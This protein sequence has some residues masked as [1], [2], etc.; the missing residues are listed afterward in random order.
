MLLATL[1]LT[2]FTL[3]Q[4]KAVQEFARAAVNKPVRDQGLAVMTSSTSVSEF[5]QK[6]QALSQSLGAEPAA[7]SALLADAP[8]PLASVASG[9]SERGSGSKSAAEGGA[10][11]TPSESA[12]AAIAESAQASAATQEDAI[13]SRPLGSGSLAA[14]ETSNVGG[15]AADAAGAASGVIA[16]ASGAGFS[17]KVVSKEAQKQLQRS[18]AE[19]AAAF[20]ALRAARTPE[21][22]EAGSLA[23]LDAA[24]NSGEAALAALIESNIA[25]DDAEEQ[26]SEKTVAAMASV[27]ALRATQ[28]RLKA[29]AAEAELASSEDLRVA[30]F[31]AL[32]RVQ[33]QEDRLV[34]WVL[35]THL[36]SC[37]VAVNAAFLASGSLAVSFGTA[38]MV[39]VLPAL[40]V[41]VTRQLR[42]DAMQGQGKA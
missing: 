20:A 5:S 3:F 38:W 29:A 34:A 7:L 10:E 22:L 17:S 30:E 16:A 13:T 35:G 9:K 1:L 15:G 23:L 18:E 19:T 4:T 12:A 25:K 14:G 41:E 2:P 40:V 24:S 31:D 27:Q 33:T 8:F 6:L 21:E 37:M 39:R 26:L 36:M 42:Q 11:G 28:R 32:T